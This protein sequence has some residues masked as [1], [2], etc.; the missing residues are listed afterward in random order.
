[1]KRLI[2]FNLFFGCAFILGICSVSAQQACLPKPDKTYYHSLLDSAG[3]NIQDTVVWINFENSSSNPEEVRLPFYQQ[4]TP[5]D[6]LLDVPG[7]EYDNK[8]EDG[9]EVL[10]HNFGFTLNSIAS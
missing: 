9:W 10:Y 7:G 5:L 8:P 3:S 1:M 4:F 2:Y 6:V